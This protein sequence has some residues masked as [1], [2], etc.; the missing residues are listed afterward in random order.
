MRYLNWDVLLFPEGSK[1]PI[2]EFKTCCSVTQDLGEQYSIPLCRAWLISV[3][4]R[5]SSIPD[6]RGPICRLCC[7]SKPSPITNTISDLLRSELASWFPIQGFS[8]QL[9]A[10]CCSSEH[11][12][13]GDP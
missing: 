10:A 1:V 4:R 9:G 8:A 12:F 6:T 13:Y 7:Q 2:Q 11:L 3:G 5:T